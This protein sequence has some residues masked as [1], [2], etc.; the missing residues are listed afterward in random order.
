MY[1]YTYDIETGGL[2]LNSSSQAFSNEP[3]PV[4]YQELDILGLDKYWLYEKDDSAPYMWAEANNY[5]YK[6]KLVAQTKGGKPLT[7]P[8]VIIKEEPE[9]NGQRLSFVN[10][11]LM[12]AKN[13]ILLERLS[14]ETIQKIYNIYRSYQ[15]KI[16]LFYV[17]F[18]GGKDSV[19]VLDLVQRALPHNAFKVLFGDTGM[20]F[21][22][23][24]KVVEDTE[25]L[26]SEMGI[27]FLKSKSDLEPSYTWRKFGPPAQ[28]IRWCCSVHK[29]TPQIL[30]IREYLNKPNF[31]GMA[32]TGIR[33]QESVNRSEYND[34]NLGEK[35]QGQYSC[36]PVLEWNS[37][38]LYLYMY[39]HNLL[40]NEAYKK[41]NSRAGC[42]VCPLAGYKNMWFKEQ[43]YSM[44]KDEKLTT[45]MFNDIIKETSSKGF[46]SQKAEDEFMDVAGW[47]ARRSGRELNISE[48]LMTDNDLDGV[49][50]VVISCKNSSWKEWMKTVGRY[51]FIDDD[52]FTLEWS[53]DLYKVEIYTNNSQIEFKLYVG[54]TKREIQ[55][56][57][58]F[59][60]ALR[61]SAY[62][63]GCK[64]CEANCPHGFIIMTNGQINI[65]N[66]CYKCL[67]CHDIDY[68]CLLANS[69]KLPKNENKMGSINRYANM[70]VELDWIKQYFST[71]DSFWTLH[72][73]G[74]NKIK[75]LRAFLNDSLITEKSKFSNFGEIVDRIGIDQQKAW[76]LILCN[77]A[78]TSEFNWW[79]T[80]VEFDTIY[81]TEILK[82]L[83]VE[84]T[85]IAKTHITSAF[86][87]IL[88]SNPI[89]ANEIG[90]GCCDYEL[91]NSKRYLNSVKR[92]SWKSPDAK[93]I[94]YSLYK[95]A[96][97]CGDYYQFSLSRLMDSSVDS[98]GVSPTQIFGLD[99]ETMI[100]LLKGLAINF[101]EYISVAFTLD[102]DNIN[103]R[104]D[105]TSA[106]IL[107]L[108]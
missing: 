10:I 95:F 24:Y 64:V 9:L 44:N 59:K 94:L 26:C 106:D 105:K 71:K 76:A 61:K 69:N 82:E 22:D 41:G 78:Y 57:K 31:R 72:S 54:N 51:S 8:E 53:G 87:N 7:A 90:L 107:E 79:V 93:V 18:S 32:F 29:T 88:I 25:K 102:L 103:L 96:E 80:K 14:Q 104:Q 98:D 42:L 68:G 49:L 40:L 65:N 45:T 101:P 20:E 37:A 43:S 108:F 99:K 12:I 47:K 55:L 74:T 81:S 6:G 2:L 16:D 17:A 85:E 5:Y 56:K 30:K 19:L 67:K 50:K 66:N 48:D 92:I 21:P 77:L 89:L 100:G 97:A 1:S 28:R 27:D 86:K 4:Y 84:E 11:D 13:A 73:L 3:R 60:I 46:Q 62:C 38:E 23:T 36:H 15:S 75:H 39:T 34:I 33:A 52:T 70:G 63:I 91:K 58:A 83:L 35:I